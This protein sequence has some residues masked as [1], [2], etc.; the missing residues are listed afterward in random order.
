MVFAMSEG[1]AASEACAAASVPEESLMVPGIGSHPATGYDKGCGG[2]LRGHRAPRRP[3]VGCVGGSLRLALVPVAAEPVS[4]G[5][6]G[7]RLRPAERSGTARET[8]EPRD[9]ETGGQLSDE[10][11]PGKNLP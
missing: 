5:E 8:P 1:L 10:N 4:A 11:A 3:E 6:I 7:P 9:A 2:A